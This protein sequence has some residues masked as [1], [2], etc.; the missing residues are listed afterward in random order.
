MKRELRIDSRYP[1]RSRGG[2]EGNREHSAPD[3]A[4]SPTS[5]LRHPSQ[6]LPGQRHVHLVQVNYC[7][8]AYSH[9]AC[10]EASCSFC[11]VRL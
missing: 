1:L 10:F 6:L 2:C 9:K 3:T 7:E 5:K 4:S 11:P 8:D